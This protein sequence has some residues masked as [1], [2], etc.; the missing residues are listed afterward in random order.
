MYSTGENEV[1]KEARI[2]FEA[3]ASLRRNPTPS[4]L[5]T[6]LPG[7]RE[8]RGAAPERPV[9]AAGAKKKGSRNKRRAKRKELNS[10]FL[11][12]QDLLVI[13][14]SLFPSHAPSP[15]S[16]ETF[17]S[18]FLFWIFKL[19][20]HALVLASLASGIWPGHSGK[21]SLP[22]K[23]ILFPYAVSVLCIMN[24]RA[25][26]TSLESYHLCLLRVNMEGF[27]QRKKNLSDLNLCLLASRLCDYVDMPLVSSK[28]LAY[29]RY[30]KHFCWMN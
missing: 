23:N 10:F 4:A 20:N 14:T 16:W 5:A 21:G 19:L 25:W 24:T 3:A 29:C 13:S 8:T 17:S 30:T 9:L 2:P 1:W 27:D 28:F 26:K 18:V 15:F 12:T 7:G 6:C 11:E 22:F